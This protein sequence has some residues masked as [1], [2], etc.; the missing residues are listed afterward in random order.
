[1]QEDM[2]KQSKNCFTNALKVATNREGEKW[3]HYYMLGKTSEKLNENPTVRLD[4]Y[5]HVRSLGYFTCSFRLS[6]FNV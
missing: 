3:M 6:N 2:L 5:Q 1:M 4:F